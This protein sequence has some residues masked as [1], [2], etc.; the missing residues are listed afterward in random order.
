MIVVFAKIKAQKGKEEE[1][2]K[3]IRNAIP[4]VAGEEGT[5]S[6]T[7]HKS[8]QDPTVFMF[9]ESYTDM[10]ALKIHGGTDYFKEMSGAM[11]ALIDGA[12]EIGV[13]EEVARAKD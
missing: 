13:Y 1:M 7:L 9:H 10:E 2:E 11:I 5:L 8:T 3:I 12:P 4:K 6:Y